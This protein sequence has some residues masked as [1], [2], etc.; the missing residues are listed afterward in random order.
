[1]IENIQ[2]V[3]GSFIVILAIAGLCYFSVKGLIFII[4]LIAN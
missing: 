1:M 3:L 4:G 2:D